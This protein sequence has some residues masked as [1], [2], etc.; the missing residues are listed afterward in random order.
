MSLSTGCF[1]PIN[2]LPVTTDA[3]TDQ[4][5]SPASDSAVETLEDADETSDTEDSEGTTDGSST[6]E[7]L[8]GCEVPSLCALWVL[9]MCG[10]ACSL[11][12][13]GNCVLTALGERLNGTIE[14]Q[15]DPSAAHQV[16]TFRGHTTHDI[17]TQNV[18]FEGDMP[19]SYGPI[20]RCQ[21]A[22]AAVFA[23]CQANPNS[24][25]LKTSTWIQDCVEVDELVCPRALGSS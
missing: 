22:D 4:T 19:V 18:T 2:K 12:D 23:D 20:L 6:H 21:V 7:G 17:L 11:D 3:T 15:T 13:T 24:E 5:T 1:D 16:L 14:V 9:P 8:L 10:D 25:C